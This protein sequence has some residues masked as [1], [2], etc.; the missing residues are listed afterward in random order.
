[1]EVSR[2]GLESELQLLAY[3]S[4]SSSLIHWARPG[5]NPASSWIL[6]GLVTAKPQQELPIYCIFTLTLLEQPYPI[7]GKLNNF[8]KK[9]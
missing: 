2:L 7:L 8:L 9:I 6:V 1:M 4:N 5:I 3:V